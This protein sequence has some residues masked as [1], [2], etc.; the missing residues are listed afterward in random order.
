MNKEKFV[1]RLQE[2]VAEQTKALET[3]IAK[4]SV[5]TL[6]HELKWADD[7]FA[8]VA[9]RDVYMRVLRTMTEQANEMNDDFDLEKWIIKN[10]IQAAGYYSKSTSTCTNLMSRCEAEGWAMVAEILE[11]CP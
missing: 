4:L 11:M 7:V 10:V 6:V 1:K 3:F 9:R 5:K 8:I 2:N